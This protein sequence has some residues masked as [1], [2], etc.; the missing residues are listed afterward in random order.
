MCRVL[1]ADD[2]IPTRDALSAF[3]S[4]S[5]NLEIVGEAADG[6]EA[7]EMVAT[8][9]SD[10]ILLDLSMP[11]MNGVEA[12]SM[13][14]KMWNDPVVIG[15]CTVQDAYTMGAFVDAGALTAI[16]KDRFEHLLSTVKRACKHKPRVFV[17]A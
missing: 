11:R 9:H 4:S 8:C 13:I 2:H 17:T 5:G 16:A 12:A 1:I 6:N 14:T 15:L 7:V 10:V 3:L